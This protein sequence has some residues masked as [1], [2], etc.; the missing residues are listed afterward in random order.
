MKQYLRIGAWI[1]PMMV[2]GILMNL[3]QSKK[4]MNGADAADA[5]AIA[6]ESI[7]MKVVG[8]IPKGAQHAVVAEAL[9]IDESGKCWLHK[10]QPL[11]DDEKSIIVHYMP[12]GTYEVEVKDSKLRWIRVPLS[13]D[14][15]KVL[16]PVKTI[17]VPK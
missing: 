5:Q 2:L 4:V 9:I 10:H 16:V 13:D 1:V 3:P 17:H 14:L 11:S 7:I 15:K 6:P 8:E 12:D